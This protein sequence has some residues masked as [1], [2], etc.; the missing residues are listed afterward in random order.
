M[1]R[2]VRLPAPGGLSTLSPIRDDLAVLR[3]ML[4]PVNPVF[5]TFSLSSD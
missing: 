2:P 3:I 4:A 5:W 1:P